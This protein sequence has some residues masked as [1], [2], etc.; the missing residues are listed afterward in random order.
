M[1]GD[2]RLTPPTPTPVHRRRREDGGFR[3]FLDRGLWPLMTLLCGLAVTRLESCRTKAHVEQVEESVKEVSTTAEATS[4]ARWK[5]LAAPAIQMKTALEA[6]SDRLAA[7]EKTQA[8]QS[9]LL[10]AREHD[11]VVEGRPAPAARRVQPALVK[12]VR[13]NAVKDA[14]ELAARAKHPT[15]AIAPI[16]LEPPPPTVAPTPKPPVAPI[17]APVA[18]V[19]TPPRPVDATPGS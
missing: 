10:V 8:A 5:K 14:K 2:E 9:T 12:A 17:V 15:P 6:L 4:R 16:P 1:L 7:V 18:P 13:E 11:F 19:Q 3:L